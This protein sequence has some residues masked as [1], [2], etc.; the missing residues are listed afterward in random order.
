MLVGN[1]YLLLVEVLLVKKGVSWT[2]HLGLRLDCC[3]EQKE[4]LPLDPVEY[5]GTPLLRGKLTAELMCLNLAP[6][7]NYQDSASKTSQSSM[8]NVWNIVDS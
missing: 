8:M 3:S 7:Q 4:H 2:H 1:R 5:S 6:Q